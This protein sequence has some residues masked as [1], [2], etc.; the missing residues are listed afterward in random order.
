MKYYRLIVALITL[1]A[2][3]GQMLHGNGVWS[4]TLE[5]TAGESISFCANTSL[6]K[7]S[8]V[9]FSNSQKADINC[10][11]S[12]NLFFLPAQF[13]WLPIETNLYKD[14]NIFYKNIQEQLYIAKFLDPPQKQFKLFYI[15][16]L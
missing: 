12:F 6:P 7:T 15:Q 11:S 13:S 14:L 1:V 2:F 3:A 16:T 9:D 4:Y 10:N 8:K 5:N